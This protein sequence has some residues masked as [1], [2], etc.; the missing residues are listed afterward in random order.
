MKTVKIIKYT[1][2]A[3]SIVLVFLMYF[4]LPVVKITNLQ[5]NFT[6][7]MHDF[8]K[9]P[10]IIIR[11][12]LITYNGKADLAIWAIVIMCIGL[13]IALFATK[14]A[15]CVSLTTYISSFIILWVYK[16]AFAMAFG[17]GES[18]MA[19]HFDC[20]YW[21]FIVFAFL[22]IIT[23]FTAFICFYKPKPKRDK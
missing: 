23:V 4:L 18:G 17:S 10:E 5:T 14:I 19:T 21:I 1:G 7:T 9:T 13:L 2:I 15:F 11:I 6:A 12:S 16:N 8:V 22:V 20:E 3:V